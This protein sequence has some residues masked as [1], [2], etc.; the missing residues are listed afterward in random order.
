MVPGVRKIAEPMTLL[1]GE[2]HTGGAT[3]CLATHDP[4]WISQAQRHL[5]LFDGRLA[6]RPVTE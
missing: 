1:I 3:V 6:D 4:R 5:Y 2:L